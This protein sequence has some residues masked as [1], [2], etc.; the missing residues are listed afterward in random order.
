MNSWVVA[1]YFL[2]MTKVT[3]ETRASVVSAMMSTP[4]HRRLRM[5]RYSPNSTACSPE[6]AIA[7]ELTVKHGF[8]LTNDVML[9]ALDLNRGRSYLPVHSYHR[10]AWDVETAGKL[11]MLHGCRGYGLLALR[12]AALGPNVQLRLLSSPDVAMLIGC[13]GGPECFRWPSSWS[14]SS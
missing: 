10:T 12:V 2:G 3:V 13:S 8:E 7:S 6:S 14:S 4:S 1:V 5:S 11:H 9:T